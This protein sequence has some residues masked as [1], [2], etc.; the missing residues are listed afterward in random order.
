MQVSWK[1]SH[2]PFFQNRFIIRFAMRSGLFGC[3]SI[4]THLQYINEGVSKLPFSYNI[5]TY[6]HFV[7][8]ITDCKEW[9]CLGE[10]LGCVRLLTLTKMS[11]KTY[12]FGCDFPCKCRNYWVTQVNWSI[13]QTDGSFLK[14]YTCHSVSY[15]IVSYI[16]CIQNQML[17]SVIL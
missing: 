13:P 10:T 11:R 9:N 14:Y 3:S 5:I 2:F 15:R 12:V 6:G 8:V 7:E 4:S 17:S 1:P 16:S